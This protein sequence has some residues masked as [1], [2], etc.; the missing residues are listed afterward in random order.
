MPCCCA[1]EREDASLTDWDRFARVEYV[2]LAMEEEG[3]YRSSDNQNE[4]WV[5]Q[6]I[7]GGPF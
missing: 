3:E 6:Q 5:S 4:L 1:Q 7:D 2:R